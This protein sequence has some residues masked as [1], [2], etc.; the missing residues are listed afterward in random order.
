MFVVVLSLWAVPARPSIFKVK[1]PDGTELV[2]KSFGDEFFHGL[3]TED[4]I[5][6]K[7][8]D[9]T[10]WY[11]SV[12]ATTL[13]AQMSCAKQKRQQINQM[14]MASARRGLQALPLHD[15]G[16]RC[17]Y[18]GNKR[19]LVI[20]VNFKD[21]KLVNSREEFYNM[22]NQEGYSNNNHVGSVRDY[23]FDQ[24]YGKLKIDFDVVGPVTVKNTYAYYGANDAGGHDKRPEEMISEACK[25]VDDQVDFKNY[26][27][28]GDGYVD[29][30]YVVYAGYG[31]N[32]TSDQDPNTIWPHEYSLY[33]AQ[34]YGASVGP[35]HQD[36]VIIDTYACSAEL[37]YTSGKTP[38]G[39]GVACH[40][41][42]HCLGFPDFYDSN[43]NYCPSMGAWDL[44]DGGSY[45]G[46]N[47]LG[48]VPS[49][50]S[51][52]ERWI[53]GWL[54]FNVLTD[55]CI[56]ENMPSL[57]DSACAYIIYNEKEHYEAYILENRQ[58]KKWFSYP[59]KAHGMLI[60]HVDYDEMSW[61]SNEV[62]TTPS[63]PRMVYV[64][65]NNTY[66]E[67]ASYGDG[68]GVY[69]A[70][71]A[72]LRGQLWPGTSGN[73]ALTNTSTPAAKTYNKN[74]DGTSFLNAEIEKITETD[75]K[76][77]FYFKGGV[78]LNVPS[79]NLSMSD[80]G[81]ALDWNEVEGAKLYEVKIVSSVPL[82]RRDVLLSESM[83]NFIVN[84]DASS[85]V[86]SKLDDYTSQP[87]WTGLR[88]YQGKYGAKLGTSKSMGALRT[89]LL[90]TQGR[91]NV[92]V[93]LT[94]FGSDSKSVTIA[95]SDESLTTIASQTITATGVAQEISF[96]VTSGKYYISIAPQK[97]MYVGPMIITTGDNTKTETIEKISQGTT[98]QFSDFDEDMDYTFQIRALGEYG[99]SE[100][101]EELVY[102]ATVSA[103]ETIQDRVPKKNSARFDLMGRPV[104]N[105]NNKF[106][107]INN[108]LIFEVK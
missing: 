15:V 58:N 55:P 99:K 104:G 92:N 66:G 62:N 97:R 96:E 28:S 2:V 14:R 86:A 39:I 24:S 5:V 93:V 19:G 65:A 85:D 80:R 3:M 42:S 44:M 56:V 12:D 83:D 32:Y 100:W 4:G 40:E 77:G 106:T 61:N 59:M 37:A 95:L 23:F 72:Q 8:D 17:P 54:E 102:K 103:I 45:G 47:G 43:Y 46:P 25:L 7:C 31:E 41:F 87:G 74:T 91:V 48:E 60:T 79:L 13:D 73:T 98:Y 89:P 69:S 26:D 6:V 75:G 107:I 1:Q 70:S 78:R 50:M 51:A 67:K 52:Y 33:A 10:G 81:V 108:H 57:S 29:Q 21:K 49:G 88:V 9:E 82:E 84:V 71:D 16:V 53:G 27:W 105:G 35:L 64:P 34:Y 36:G 76:I 38:N 90:E 63:H 11:R 18:E 94:G 22:F 30:V 68:K 20:L 101:S